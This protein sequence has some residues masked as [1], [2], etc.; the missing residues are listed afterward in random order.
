VELELSLLLLGQHLCPGGVKFAYNLLWTIE[1][2][3][4]LA[5][6]H[7]SGHVKGIN[8]SVF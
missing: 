2:P 3:P 1:F 5:I 8:I 4:E 6:I 7:L